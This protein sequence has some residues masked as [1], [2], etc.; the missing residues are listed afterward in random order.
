[1]NVPTLLAMLGDKTPV[2]VSERIDPHEQNAFKV[3]QHSAAFRLIRQITYQQSHAVVVQTHSAGNYFRNYK[4]VNV[5]VIPNPN[6]INGRV[7]KKIKK[8]VKVIVAVGRLHPQK[9][10]ETLINAMALV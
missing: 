2:I 6:L 7:K 3:D 8:E 4:N 10:H 5:Q 9:D 1:M